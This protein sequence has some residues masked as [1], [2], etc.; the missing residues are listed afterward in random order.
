[1]PGWQPPETR[2]AG[3]LSDER[4]T[5]HARQW[6]RGAGKTT[7]I[8]RQLEAIGVVTFAARAERDPALRKVHESSP[9]THPELQ[10]YRRAGAYEAALYRFPCVE[11]EA[12]FMS[13]VMNNY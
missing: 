10:R 2:G 7:F 6:A 4:A 5:D 3:R 9:A 1:M 12:F 8:E 13:K 11:M